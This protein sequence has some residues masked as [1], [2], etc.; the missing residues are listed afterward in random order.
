ML[1]IVPNNYSG[2]AEDTPRP[3]PVEIEVE[4]GAQVEATYSR[5]EVMARNAKRVAA[6]VPVCERYKSRPEIGISIR[7]YIGPEKTLPPEEVPEEEK[8]LKAYLKNISTFRLLD[9][10]EEKVLFTTI[11]R[12]LEGLPEGEA[13]EA[14][15]KSGN[16]DSNKE[17]ELIELTAACEVLT[18]TN[19][20]LVASIAR[21]YPNIIPLGDRI[22][23][24]SRGLTRAIH[25]FDIRKGLKFSTFAY[26]WIHQAVRDGLHETSRTIR[27]SR[28]VHERKIKVERIAGELMAKL[29]AR[30]TI[31]QI[32]EAGDMTIKEVE[33]ANLHGGYALPSLDATFG[34]GITRNDKEKTY[35]EAFPSERAE[36]EL[37][38][39]ERRDAS[40][41]YMAAIFS[42]DTLSDRDRLIL[43]LR[44]GVFIE[45]LKEISIPNIEIDYETV[46]K[47]AVKNNIGKDRDGMTLDEVGQVLSLT[48]ERVRQLEAASMKA[49]RAA[50][51]EDHDI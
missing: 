9:K 49:L 39:V 45:D 46:M 30:P 1:E 5:K 35:G 17:R 11:D 23:D 24:G 3:Q 32:A 22:Q 21:G 48:R 20:R 8:Q 43:S 12:G 50:L 29:H 34:T 15:L 40:D 14:F 16:I 7:R 47:N 27:V 28:D 41:R 26:D 31:A 44:Y 13:L 36:Q 18:L 10:A 33:K 51:P 6:I 2:E 4:D 37:E 25:R 19:L 38:E 42:I